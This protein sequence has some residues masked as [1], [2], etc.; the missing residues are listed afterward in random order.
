M[1]LS[2]L[3]KSFLPAG[4]CVI[5]IQGCGPSGTNELVPAAPPIEQKSGFPFSTKEPEVFQGDIII[6]GSEADR[7]FVARKAGWRRED[8][9]RDGQPWR[10]ELFVDRR[11]TID[12][13]RKIY[14][15]HEPA[16]NG[17]DSFAGL[18]LDMFRGKEHY[19]FDEA[20][21]PGTVVRYKVRNHKY[22]QDEILIDVDTTNGMMVRQE[23]RSGPASMDQS[24]FVYELRN[25]RSD[26]DDSV[27][28]LPAGYKKVSPVEFNKNP[29]K[30]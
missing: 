30:K 13:E 21:R 5:I 28:A 10:S 18:P 22:M 17:V 3:R 16:A 29:D 14:V 2:K 1:F 9:Y 26:V 27:F 11:Y 8:Q 24:G 19:E 15:E 25:L 23:F 6:N 4:L 7:S 20:A 12:H